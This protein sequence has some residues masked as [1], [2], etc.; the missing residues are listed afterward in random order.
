MK[1]LPNTNHRAIGISSPNINSETKKGR[2][3]MKK[4]KEI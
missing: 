3:M 2:M 1:L 4:R